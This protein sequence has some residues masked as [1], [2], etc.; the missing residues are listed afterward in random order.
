MKKNSLS[1]KFFSTLILFLFT[2]S[3]CVATDQR[4]AEEVPAITFIEP[5]TI[6]EEKQSFN[7]LRQSVKFESLDVF[8][9]LSSNVVNKVIQDQYGLIWIAT[10]DGLNKYDGK[11]FTVYK[12]NVSEANSLINNA[13][14]DIFEDSNGN[15]WVGTDGG[16][17]KFNRAN[18]FFTHYQHNKA[19]SNSLPNN[20]VR[21]IYE[22]SRGNLWIGTSGGGL[23]KFDMESGEFST[24]I[25]EDDNPYSLANNIVRAIYEDSRGYLWIGT[26]NGLD[27]FDYETGRF[28]HFN[29][30][31]GDD[32]I[33]DSSSFGRGM[34]GRD[35]SADVFITTETQ[36][37]PSTQLPGNHIMDIEEDVDGGLW[38]ATYGGG[39]KKFDPYNGSF[40]TF[41]NVYTQEASL[42]SNNVNDI[43]RDSQDNFWFGTNDGLNLYDR[44]N[45]R[46]VR[47]MSDPANQEDANSLSNG[48][49]NSV[50]EDYAGMYWIGTSG[51]GLNV[52]SPTMNRFQHVKNDPMR[53][54][55][56]SSNIVWAFQ[57]D[58]D[59]TLWV[60]NDAGVDMMR[61]DAGY[62][63]HYDPHPEDLRNENDAV[64]TIMRDSTGMLWIGTARGLSWFNYIGNR[65]V[66]VSSY[67]F[68]NKSDIKDLDDVTITDLQEDRAGNIWIG[69]YGNGILKLSPST[70]SI[71]TLKYE[72]DA[73]NGISSNIV[74]TIIKDKSGQLWVGTIGGGL[75]LL[76]PANNHFENFQNDPESINSISD[77]NITSLAIDEN[78][79]LWIGTYNGLNRYDPSTATFKTYT[80][81][82]GLISDTILGIVVD[83]AGLIWISN[84]NGLSQFDP[85]NESFVNFTYRDGLQGSEFISGS[86][87]L[88]GDGVIYFGGMDGYN[89]FYP[90]QL[91]GNSYIPQI[92]LVSLTQSGEGIALD[93]GLEELDEITLK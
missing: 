11:K 28:F 86:C 3:A 17:D 34:R 27:R 76:N 5:A 59:G 46:F 35:T 8:A 45:D 39:I 54:S 21:A 33:P 29:Q 47:F 6:S 55:S 71:T 80:I 85:E 88:G 50:F 15:L 87:G 25:H 75:N 67:F 81:R 72:P 79:M 10:I 68:Q 60:A 24:Y 77:N 7:F 51:G 73:E 43:Y 64:Y 13:V 58:Y 53:P 91:I 2:L 61:K 22:D 41:L 38:L 23:S 56:L 18:D 40:D 4:S 84:G 57:Q 70:G 48:I 83:N 92:V 36:F 49:V 1:L 66:T 19:V 74:N 32:S 9:G 78:G 44:R 90:N 52:F 14:W 37:S 42:S 31:T 65:F 63:I 82:D 89:Y 12:R 62:F 16:L 93:Y 69:T 26:W 20:F 30:E